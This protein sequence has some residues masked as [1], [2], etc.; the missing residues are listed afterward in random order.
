MFSLFKLASSAFL[1][2]SALHNDIFVNLEYG[3]GKHRKSV[4]FLNRE[5]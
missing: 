1:L 3:K 4:I 5:N 2:G